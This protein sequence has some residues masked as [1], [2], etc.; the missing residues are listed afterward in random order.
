MQGVETRPTETECCISL[1][2]SYNSLLHV[3]IIGVTM[4]EEQTRTLIKIN[5]K[6]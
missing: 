1:T 5:A 6:Y 2:D 3:A 4:K